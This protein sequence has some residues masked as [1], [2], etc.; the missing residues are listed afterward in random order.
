MEKNLKEKIDN[1]DKEIENFSTSKTKTKNEALKAER[2]LAELIAGL[3][4]GIFIGFHLDDYFNT[5]PL[6]LIVLIILGLAG[7]F[8]NIYKQVSKN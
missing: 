4:F 8:Y 3:I 5:K 1:L 6:F 7:S 2:V